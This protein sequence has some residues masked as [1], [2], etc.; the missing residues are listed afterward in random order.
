M[1][2][3]VDPSAPCGALLVQTLKLRVSLAFDLLDLF[4][5]MGQLVLKLLIP[6]GCRIVGDDLLQF[7]NALQQALCLMVPVIGFCIQLF[8]GIFQQPHLRLGGPLLLKQTLGLCSGHDILL[9]PIGVQSGAELF[10]DG[11]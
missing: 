3:L 1:E 8:T 5:A 2:C 7:C 11:I 4:G 6:G 10:V 9:D